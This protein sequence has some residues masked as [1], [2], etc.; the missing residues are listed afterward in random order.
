MLRNN[1]R[2][3]LHSTD[4][5][6]TGA[7]FEYAVVHVQA[8]SSVRFARFAYNHLKQKEGLS[9]LYRNISGK[10][11]T[12]GNPSTHFAIFLIW[13]LLWTY[14]SNHFTLLNEILYVICDVLRDRYV[15]VCIQTICEYES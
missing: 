9:F 11:L 12:L 6:E 13:G 7:C 10:G 15:I 4:L 14:V 2:T 8:H 5:H 3:E 1:S